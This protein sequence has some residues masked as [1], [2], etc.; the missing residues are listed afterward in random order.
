[1]PTLHPSLADDG[2]SEIEAAAY[3]RGWSDALD[4]RD[5]EDAGL[6]GEE[7]TCAGCGEWFDTAEHEDGG[8]HWD[9]EMAGPMCPGCATT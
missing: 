9:D 1:M 7:L 8:D 6:D 2:M 3:A 5:R 4:A